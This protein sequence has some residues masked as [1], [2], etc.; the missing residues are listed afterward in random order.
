MPYR[1]SPVTPSRNARRGG[2]GRRRIA[3]RRAR[4]VPYRPSPGTASRMVVACRIARCRIACRIAR[5]SMTFRRVRSC[6]S[7]DHVS[8]HPGPPRRPHVS[9]MLTVGCAEGPSSAMPRPN[10]ACS[11]RRQPLFTN[12][13][14]FVWP[15]R[16][17][18]ARSAARLRLSVGP[19]ATPKAGAGRSRQRDIIGH[20]PG[21]TEHIPNIF[22]TYSGIVEHEKF[23]A[24][25][26]AGRRI[27]C[28]QA[29]R[30]GNGP[31]PDRVPSIPSR[32][33]SSVAGSRTVW[34]VAAG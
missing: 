19:L 1:L 17:I 20:R 3:C 26:S 10:M 5:R 30:G 32:A 8:S 25:G 31:S 11:R 24:C 34:P 14:S 23:G 22:R 6:L 4:R 7:P 28:H 2:N 33:V 21:I 16:F 27:A 13:Y 12:T 18:M 15:W 9:A 29:R